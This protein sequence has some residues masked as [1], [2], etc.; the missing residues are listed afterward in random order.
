M[1]AVRKQRVT[2]N[3]RAL[4]VLAFLAWLLS[5][6]LHTPVVDHNMASMRARVGADDKPR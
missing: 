4:L 2:T 3:Y 6:A 1:K 5:R